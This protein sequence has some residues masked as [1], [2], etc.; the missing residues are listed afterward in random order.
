MFVQIH[1]NTG[2]IN[3]HIR[4]S[5]GMLPVQ[6]VNNVFNLS[7]DNKEIELKY[8]LY[9]PKFQQQETLVFL[10]DYN[11]MDQSS[12]KRAINAKL[13]YPASTRIASA[14][15]SY[16]SLMNVNGTIDSI[17]PLANVSQLGCQFIVFTTL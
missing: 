8:S 15:V 4:A 12:D 6:S 1:M 16:E 3:G 7:F 2:D 13:Y 17:L 14:N 5:W 11:A 10:F 9:T